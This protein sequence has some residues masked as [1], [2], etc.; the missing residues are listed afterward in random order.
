MKVR[1]SE[2]TEA[3]QPGEYAASLPGVRLQTPQ[4]HFNSTG[5][6]LKLRFGL[7]PDENKN[8]R[9]LPSPAKGNICFDFK[10][11]TNLPF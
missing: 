6:G 8:K 4:A 11:C 7:S 10:S 3:V 1:V 2:A 9:L 5:R